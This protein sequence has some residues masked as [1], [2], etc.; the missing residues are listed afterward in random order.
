[1]PTIIWGQK[2]HTDLLIKKKKKESVSFRE[3][4]KYSLL[5]DTPQYK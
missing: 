4:P 1:M 5:A 3:E 2:G